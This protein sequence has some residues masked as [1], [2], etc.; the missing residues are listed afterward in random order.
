M[1]IS[2]YY[3][4]RWNNMFPW[5]I[6]IVLFSPSVLVSSST[7]GG[8]KQ[9]MITMA[10]AAPTGQSRFEEVR[11][12][13]RRRRDRERRREQSKPHPGRKGNKNNFNNQQQQ[14]QQQQQGEGGE[15]YEFLMTG[16]SQFTLFQQPKDI[17][18]GTIKALQSAFLGASVGLVSVISFPILGVYS[19]V[20]AAE[21]G[22]PEEKS[23]P[24]LGLIVGTILGGITGFVSALA[25]AVTA[26]F[27]VGFGLWNTFGSMKSKLQGMRWDERTRAWIHYNLKEEAEELNLGA[28]EGDSKRRT[29]SHVQDTGFYDFLGVQPDASAKEIKRAYYQKAKTMHPDKRPDDPEKAAEDFLKLHSAYQTL[30]DEQKR[31]DYDKY[32]VSGDGGAIGDAPFDV[33]VFFAVMFDFQ[34]VEPYIGELTIAAFIDAVI[35]LSQMANQD[36]NNAKLLYEQVWGSDTK[37][38]KRQVEIAQNLLSRIEAYVA[39]TQSAEDFR[40][41]AADEADK[42]IRGGGSSNDLLGFTDQLLDTIGTSLK[43]EA[44]HYLAFHQRTPFIA[45]PFKGTLYAASRK[46]NLWARRLR[47]ATKTIQLVINAV[48]IEKK[49]GGDDKKPNKQEKDASEYEELLPDLTDMAGAYI[50]SDISQAIQGACWRLFFDS[51]VEK[52]TRRRRAEAL[53]MLG[54]EFL[55]LGRPKNRGDNKTECV[56]KNARSEGVKEKLKRAFEISQMKAKGE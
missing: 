12:R 36:A 28:S 50:L 29:A 49:D 42:I 21:D 26:A 37:P 9:G 7:S 30:S 15:G 44:G 17:F 48:K 3:S 19:Q 5:L 38:R 23:H 6:I 16:A 54:Q 8:N 39:G 2:R 53:E 4:R 31:A 18:E 27:Q 24:I 51:G 55:R 22:K 41:S 56:D 20:R 52:V 25:G 47:S 45:W 32:G 1:T 46:K 33:S 35:K 43:L 14:Q 40:Q 11:D 10:D 13:E 34:Q